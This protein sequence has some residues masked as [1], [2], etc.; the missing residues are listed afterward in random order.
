MLSDV[1]SNRKDR[2]YQFWKDRSYNKQLCNR[3]V[4]EQKLEY[5]HNNPVSK[6]WN[7]VTDVEDYCFST[8][9]YYLQNIN[10]WDF[11]THYTE[12]I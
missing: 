3:K 9:K 10:E 1:K 6:K 7:L 5:I 12:H 8:A 2:K 4:V 11:V